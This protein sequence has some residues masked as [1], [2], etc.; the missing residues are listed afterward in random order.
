M[1]DLFIVIESLGIAMALDDRGTPFTCPLTEDG[2]VDWEYDSDIEWDELTASQYKL[3]M[4]VFKALQELVPLT[5]NVTAF[6]K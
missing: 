4:G 6:V 1:E 5:Q 3:F 2:T